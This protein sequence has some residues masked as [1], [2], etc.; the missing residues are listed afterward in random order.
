MIAGKLV[1]LRFFKEADLQLAHTKMMAVD[2]LSALWPLFLK[3]YTE[4]YDD[5]KKTGFWSSERG[6]FL[7]WTVADTRM[8]GTIKFFKSW[9]YVNG[10]EIGYQIFDDQDHR[11]GYMTEAL[12]LLAR[13]LFE[14]F[15]IER[16]QVC[17]SIENAASRKVAEKVGFQF[18]GTL[19]KTIFVRGRYHDQNVFSIL[20]SEI[21]PL[22]T[23]VSKP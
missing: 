11:H 20:R 3:S 18:E 19:R 4:F 16:I 23:K 17:M 22:K 14:T 7:I 5:F 8:V 9:N 10:F 2:D 21:K 1:E 15:H 6:Q 12:D 13:L